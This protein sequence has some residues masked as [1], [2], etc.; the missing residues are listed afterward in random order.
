M[1]LVFW[2]QSLDRDLIQGVFVWAVVGTFGV[3]FAVITL[4]SVL[5]GFYFVADSLIR[6]VT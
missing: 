6:L 3:L 2:L 1:R 4:L 5:I